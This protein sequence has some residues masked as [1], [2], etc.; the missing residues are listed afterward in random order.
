MNLVFGNPAGWW[1]LLGVPAI[2]LVHM[3][4]IRARE[5]PIS[6]LF[7]LDH[8]G[9]ES[10]EGRVLDR[11]R[12]S[13]QLWLQLLAVLL[14]TWLLLQ[15]RWIRTDSFQR[16]VVVLD[17][18]ASMAAV[19]NDLP[20]RVHDALVPL[21]RTSALTEWRLMESDPSRG[22]RYAGTSL[23]GLIGRIKDWT[24]RLGAHALNPAL[25]VARSLAGP[26]GAVILVT[27]HQPDNPPPGIA[28]LGVGVPRNQCGFAGLRVDG[29]P[30]GETWAAAIR[31]YGD[32]PAER[33]WDLVVD[34]QPASRREIRLAPDET[35]VVTGAFPPGRDRFELRMPPDALPTDDRLPVLRPRP[36]RLLVASQP[37]EGTEPFVDQLLGAM[38]AIDRVRAGQEPD[39]V[40]YGFTPGV[41][42]ETATHRICL[43]RPD[44]DTAD[45]DGLPVAES[46]TLTRD[47]SWGGLLCRPVRLGPLTDADQALVWQGSAPL[48]VLRRKGNSEQLLIGFDVAASNADRVPAFVILLHRFVERIRFAKAAPTAD[49]VDVNQSLALPFDPAGEEIVVTAET[50][51]GP[52]P[53][54]Y[55]VHQGAL[56][57]APFFS[58]FFTVAQGEQTWFDGAA[59]FADLREADL[60]HT[61]SFKLPDHHVRDLRLANSRPDPWSAVWGALLMLVVL[62]A[63]A[64]GEPVS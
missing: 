2:L 26:L 7:L 12:T 21:G 6:T 20:N 64:V 17:S 56:V 33:S 30:G 8:V 58:G 54:A 35:R 49:N 31:N 32:I 29:E 4:Q 61:E 48:I 24:P 10:R 43:P 38:P 3:L 11:L 40:V 15:P 5:I 36:K 39:L 59:Q 1:A 13:P 27:D 37:P 62:S 28:V 52:D 22:A 47:L 57:R 18:S 63:W 14:L 51:T 45:A 25:G 23:P 41:L 42:P 34:G 53:Y 55:P 44:A 19:L 46:H 50:E 9:P 16:V 60:R